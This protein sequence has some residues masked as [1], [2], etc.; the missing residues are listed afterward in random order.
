MGVVYRARQLRLNRVVALKMILAG[1]HAGAEAAARFLAE[2][3]AI[4]RLEH[5]NIVRIHYIDEHDG[6]PY[7]EM[8]YVGGG[9]LADRL[10]GAPKSPRGSA[11]LVGLLARAVAEA[12][13]AGIVHRDLKPANILL[14]PEGTPKVA[15]FGLAKSIGADSGLTRTDSILGSPSYMA[16][17]QAEAKRQDVGPA[18]DIYGLGAILYEQLTGRPPFV[19]ATV[20]D[21]LQLVKA[22]EPVAPSRLVPGLPRDVETIALKCLEK[23]L[24]RRYES[25]AALA[26]E[27]DRFVQGAP[28]V[29]RP[30]PFWERGW[31]W[32]RRR[33]AIAALALALS[34]ASVA[35]LTMGVVSYV[36]IRQ[37][38]DEARDERMVALSAR[39]EEATARVRADEARNAA[40]AES[41]RAS[42][43][44]A[45]ALRAGRPLGWRGDALG[46]LS[47]LA[48][49]PTPRRDFVELRT[50]AVADLGEL[51][52]IEVARLEGFRGT[53]WSLE[54]RPDS[55]ALA[56]ATANGD[57]DL[58]DVARRQHSWQVADPAGK[59]SSAGWPSVTDPHIQVRFLPDGGLA[60]TTWSH[61]VEFLG[62]SGTP[63]GRPPIVGGAANSVGLEVDRAGRRLAVGWSDG[64]IEVHDLAAGGLRRTIQGDPLTFALSPDGHW[65]ATAGPDGSVQIRPAD[66]DDPP[67]ML[68]THQGGIVSLTF[69]PDGTTIASTSWDHATKLWDVAR[70]EAG[71]ILRGH[72]EKVTDVAFSPDGNWVATV[73]Q[74]YTARIWDART[75]QTLAVLPGPWFMHT[76]AFSPD[77]Q[78]LAACSLSKGSLYQIRG[79][80]ESRLLVGHRNGTQCLAFDPRAARPASGA[81][82]H[83]MM[84]WDAE[85]AR[86]LRQWMAHDRYVTAITYSP[87][88]SLLASGCGGD[89]PCDVRIWEADTGSLRHILSG[90][91]T[92]I[93]AL[94]FDPSGRR[95]AS[96][97]KSGALV[98]WDVA[99]G[100]ILRRE[101]VGPSWIWSLVFLDEG[102]RLATAVSFGP[103]VVYDLEGNDPPRTV[104]VPGGMR[105]FIVDRARNDLI[106]AGNGGMLTR[107]SLRDLSVGHRLDKG[108]DGMIESLALHPGGKL[109]VTGGG[110][111]RRIILR[112]AETFEP[113]V[114]LPSWTGM[115]KDLAFDASGRWLAIAGAASDVGLWDLGLVRDELDAAGLAWD[116]PAPAVAS[117]PVPV[118]GRA[119]ATVPVLMP[120]NVDP[121]VVSAVRSLR[122]SGFQALIAGRAADA[123]RDLEGARDGYRRLAR[124]APGDPRAAGMLANSLG[125]LSNALR[126]THRPAESLAAQREAV[127]ILEG[128]SDP[129]A[130]H[131]YDLA[132]GYA[133]LSILT[134]DGSPAPPSAD[135]EALAHRAVATLRRSIESGLSPGQDVGGDP[136]FDPIRN[137]P[138]FRALLLD[139]SFPR[140]PFRR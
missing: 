105:R 94:A 49:M 53:V 51:D 70:R 59:E 14:T 27:L 72:K 38:L 87:D 3:E 95:L 30:V 62:P 80:R 9:N 97:D 69:S 19:G 1:D 135:R 44:E 76:V 5:A 137:R 39:N 13:R 93:H 6:W 57:L 21:T 114:N 58:W 43:S 118:A 32:A 28:I 8:E 48:T 33:P 107:V 18:A 68:G 112:D 123:V 133:Q 79:R 60:R 125:W 40:L 75:G 4:A 29:A 131:L 99:T 52:V 117:A 61:R 82:D 119:P 41:Y 136:D 46:I 85:S 106:V 56:T 47:R 91:S 126:S 67:V 111:D 42:L 128:L 66:G 54:F 116:R 15:D 2:A 100:R 22:A 7:F 132:C 86:P 120:G 127:A 65:L 101:T 55:G 45:R 78:Y 23:S 31:K 102:R 108:H 64:R 26:D 115:V 77:G 130:G 73:S 129:E 17:E 20:L 83:R 74:D 12:H 134:A 124:A 81:D 90:H 122:R 71:V 88:G 16:P 24:S 104:A 103:V 139:R 138:D 121:A 110:T 140:D 63:S 10:D 25:A 36:R 50:E 98:I 89:V 113:L 109:L 92:G 34:L 37:A 11:R 84:I 35:M 96:G